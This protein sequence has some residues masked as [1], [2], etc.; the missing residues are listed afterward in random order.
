MS[1]ADQFPPVTLD[2]MITHDEVLERYPWLSAQIVNTL[3]RIA[4]I[5]AEIQALEDCQGVSRR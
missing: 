2:S 4:G 3:R 1:D 5:D